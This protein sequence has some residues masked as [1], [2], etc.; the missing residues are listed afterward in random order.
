MEIVGSNRFTPLICVDTILD[1]DMGLM[2]LINK[3]Y[4]NP[5]IF[6][7][8]I[9]DI[10]LLK[11]VY[12]RDTINPLGVILKD[13]SYRDQIDDW[14]REFL[15]TKEYDILDNSISTEIYNLL[16][17]FQKSGYIT[18][19]ILYFSQAQRDMLYRMTSLDSFS[20]KFYYEVKDEVEFKYNPI[21]VKSIDQLLLFPDVTDA[22]F[23]IS[24]IGYNI[25]DNDIKYTDS[26]TNTIKRNN[27]IK[28]FSMYDM[29]ILEENNDTE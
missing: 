27:Q 5:Q 18:P 14:Y 7:H 24:D 6:D 23:Y 26:L 22:V 13:E 12:K 2:R 28:L 3:E 1:L 21:F 25:E 29:S 9:N 17:D 8:S 16:F 11:R 4:V 15:D 20:K 10:D 19:T